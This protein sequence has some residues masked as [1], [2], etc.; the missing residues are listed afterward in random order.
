M[1]ARLRAGE[2]VWHVTVF[3]SDSRLMAEFDVE[4]TTME[5]LLVLVL[6]HRRVPGGE[7]ELTSNQLA[8]LVPGLPMPTRGSAFVGLCQGPRHRS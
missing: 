4:H 5:M 3:G 1:G 2:V 8:A 7:V 6:G